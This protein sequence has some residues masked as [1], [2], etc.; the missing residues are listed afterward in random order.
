MFNSNLKNAVLAG[1]LASSAVYAGL[2]FFGSDGE[3]MK[4]DE[5]ESKKSLFENLGDSF[6]FKYILNKP[7]PIKG[8]LG[9]KEASSTPDNKLPGTNKTPHHL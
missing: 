1:V 2:Y 5:A 6:L 7:T 4:L 9:D 3:G 8:S